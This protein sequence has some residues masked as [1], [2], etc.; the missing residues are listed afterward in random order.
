MKNIVHCAKVIKGNFLYDFTSK[1]FLIQ[2]I[3]EELFN[4][5]K[6][7]FR[8]EALMSKSRIMKEVQ[9]SNQSIS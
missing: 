8:K 5:L 6:N 4:K 1:E 3:I 7:S 2:A 9:I